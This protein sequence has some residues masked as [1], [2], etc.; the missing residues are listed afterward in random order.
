MLPFVGV[1]SLL[2][3][4]IRV[5]PKPSRA[6]Y[7]CQRL[8]APIASGFVVWLTGMIASSL[9]YR[10]AKRLASQSRY[11][12]AGVFAAVAVAAIWWSVNLTADTG[13]GAAF[14]PID[15]P[16]N[17]MGIGKGIYPGRVVW[18]HDP[19]AT[20]WDGKTGSWWDEGNLDQQLVDD[21]V[22]RSLRTLTG[23]K[24]DF[25]AWDALFRYFNKTHNVGDVAYRPG[26]KIVIKINMN[27]DSG[28]TWAAN[29]GMPSPQMIHSVLDQLFHVVGVSGSAVTIYDAARYIGDPIYDKIHGDPDPNFQSVTFV[30]NST[31]NGRIGA[32]YDPAHPIRFANV[33]VPGNATAYLPRSVTEAK[34]LINMAL[35][36]AHQLFGVTLCGK[37]LFGS[38]YWPSNGGWTPEPLHN[39]GNRDLPMGSYNCLVDLIGHSQLG[40]KTLLYMVDGLYGARHQ[41]GEVIRYA[42]FGNDWTSSLFMSQDPIAIDSVGLDFLRNEPLATD[43][44]GPGVD[45]YLHEGA[46]ANNPS[47]HSFYDPG[48]TGTRLASLGVH[49]HWNNAVDKKYSR[50]LGRSEG[51]ELVTPPLA[52]EEGPVENQTKGTKYNY[53]RHAVQEAEDGDTIEVAPGVYRKAVSFHGKGLTIR[54]KDPNDP[55][56]V[57][58]TVIRGVTEGVT[59]AGGEDA[60]S[61]LTGFTISGATRGIYCQGASPVILNC[62]I[63]DNVEAGIKLWESSNPTV[64]NCIIAG[65]G[66]DGMEMWASQ[67]GRRVAYNYATILHCTIVGNSG[68]GI[69]GGKPTVV[70]SIVYG[71]NVGDQGD[72]IT[73]DTAIV[74]Y[75]DVLGGWPGEGNI[76]AYPQWVA[77]GFWWPDA[78]DASRPGSEPHGK[79]VWH[80]GL[81][82]YHLEASSPCI[83]AGDPAPASRWGLFDIDGQQ[84]PFGIRPDIGCDEF[85]TKPQAAAK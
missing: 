19:D 55:N 1:A 33:S 82:D 44:T 2:W 71:N 37:N 68:N 67:E 83:D 35:F 63:V 17:P 30:C 53:I 16:N 75:C 28:G 85:V 11:G 72:Q 34:Y 59:F 84:R 78:S 23:Q 32:V 50:N 54:S 12:I 61:V 62:R 4:L 15:P 48:G 36:R 52:V 56:V 39:F 14:V 60:N 3:F 45:N 38:I 25:A 8:A 43:C 31:R 9:A 46:M 21:M 74:R 79:E 42:S 64:A 51:I 65:N 49:E 76:D 18:V 40:G 47:S 77:P 7:P 5:I 24:E 29:A 10:K 26:E 80:P 13:A 20:S 57:A 6:T 81:G 41:N 22:S 58:A 66:G 69:R 73:A 70:N 27:Q